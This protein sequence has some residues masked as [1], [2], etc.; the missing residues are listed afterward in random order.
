MKWMQE[1]N[2]T[3]EQ[4]CCVLVGRDTRPSGDRLTAAVKAGAEAM[5]SGYRDIGV[6]TTPQLHYMVRCLNTQGDYGVPSEAGYYDKLA[7]AYHELV[8]PAGSGSERVVF[9]DCANGVGAS[10]MGPLQEAIG[11]D[12]LRMVAF[13]VDISSPSLLNFQVRDQLQQVVQCD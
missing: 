12:R 8:S 11:A 2:L 4:P 5:R 7:R 6:V 3:M 13:N 10:K 9:V 1:W